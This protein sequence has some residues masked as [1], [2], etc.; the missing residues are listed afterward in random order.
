MEYHHDAKTPVPVQIGLSK[1]EVV[2]PKK[3]PL[4][5]DYQEFINKYLNI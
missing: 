5:K 3:I 1:F 4:I 2:F